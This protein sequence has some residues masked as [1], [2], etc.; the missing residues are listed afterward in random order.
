MCSPWPTIQATDAQNAEPGITATSLQ[1]SVLTRIR[2]QIDSTEPLNS[3][4]RSLVVGE[5]SERSPCSRQ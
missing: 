3:S 5:L 1:S 2:E 4:R